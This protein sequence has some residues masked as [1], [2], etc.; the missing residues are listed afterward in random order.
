MNKYSWLII[1]AFFILIGFAVWYTK[2]PAC[3]WALLLTP[4]VTWN[5]DKDKSEI[6]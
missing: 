2:E 5:N 4:T 6:E 3:L 1:V